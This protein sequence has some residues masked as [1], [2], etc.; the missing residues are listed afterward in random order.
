M[1]KQ[2]LT[3]EDM[4]QIGKLSTTF[5]L[6]DKVEACGVDFDVTNYLLYLAYWCTWELNEDFG[7]WDADEVILAV[8]YFKLVANT[9]K[10]QNI[11]FNGEVMTAR[12]AGG[13]YYDTTI[14]TDKRTALHII[15]TEEDNTSQGAINH[16]VQYLNHGGHR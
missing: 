14:D 16:L 2:I 9:R 4:E 12:E 6:R 13:S 5:V 11:N 3:M 1:K 7:E 10:F 8:N 15:Q